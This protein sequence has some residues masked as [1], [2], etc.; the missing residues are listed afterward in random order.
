MANTKRHYL[1]RSDLC[2]AKQNYKVWVVE[3]DNPTNKR[4]Y[5]FLGFCE[6]DEWTAKKC[7]AVY[8]HI[9]SE[10]YNWY[11]LSYNWTNGRLYLR[12]QVPQVDQY[13]TQIE[14]PPTVDKGDDE[15]YKGKQPEY[16]TDYDT[17]STNQ[18]PT[19]EHHSTN[20]KLNKEESFDAS[21]IQ[22][23]PIGVQPTLSPTILT[24]AIMSTTLT[25]PTITV[26]AAT[27]ASTSG[28]TTAQTGGSTT[29]TTS[30]DPKQQICYT[31][32]GVF[33]CYC[34]RRPLNP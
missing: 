27:T 23:S 32:A 20:N 7:K 29:T 19:K 6:D 5:T 31:A 1:H 21:I 10:G 11:A 22:N 16:Q 24:T 18:E 33:P 30:T 13:N 4:G 28:T 9:D 25:Q 26:Q 34:I 15:S 17:D 3:N 12:R 2:F 14:S 8:E